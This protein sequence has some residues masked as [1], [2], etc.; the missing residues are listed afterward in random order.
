[1]SPMTSHVVISALDIGKPANRVLS[2]QQV[3]CVA[4]WLFV[5]VWTVLNKL[6]NEMTTPKNNNERVALG[7]VPHARSMTT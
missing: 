5:I 1:M 2:Q 7:V 3:I 4:L 6:I